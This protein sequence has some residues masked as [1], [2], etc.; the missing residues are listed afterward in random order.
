MVGV[1]GKSKGCSTCRRRKKGCDQKRPVCGQCLTSGNICGGYDRERTF[2][3]HP[4]S[5]KVQHAIFIRHTKP[6]ILPLPGSINRGA[7]ESQCKSL[8][9]DLYM[10]QGEAACRDDFIIRCG[11]PMN[12]TEVIQSVSKQDTSLADA[13]SALSISRVGQGHRDVRL[14]HESAK[15]YGKA[16]RELQLAL[17]DPQRMYSDHV[18]MA[19]MLLGLYEVFEGPAFNSRSWMAHATGAARLIQLRGPKRHQTWLTHHPFLA[20]RIPTIYAAILQRKATYLA[21]EEWRTVP[22]EFQHRTYFDRMVDLGTLIP[23]I[24]E[25]F[26]ILRECDSDIASELAQ[27][28]DECRDLQTK[29]NKWRDGTKKG[30]TPRVV[31]H[32]PL[33]QSSYPFTTDLWFENHLFV[34]ARLVYHTCSLALSEVGN[35]VLQALNLRDQKIL[36]SIDRASLKELFDAEGQAANVCRCVSYCL[37]SEMGA[38][39]ANIVNFPAN[40]AFAYYQRTGHTAATEWLEKAFRG[41]KLR[42]LHVNNVFDVLLPSFRDGDDRMRFSKRESST[43]SSSESSVHSPASNH[44]I[45]SHTFSN[46]S[47]SSDA[48]TIF[49]YEDPSK[50]YDTNYEPD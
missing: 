8:F 2:I 24:L 45:A 26:D 19:C 35:E 7:V 30:A 34:H 10:P 43:E 9:W 1:P 28:L 11:Q 18:L 6:P 36:Y 14:V 48:T 41:A 12:W 4:A 21:T 40:L 23:G 17:F 49:V 39:G 31:E 29:M 27:L 38:W 46:H 16:L 3:L 44:S 5:E 42:G 33:D 13:F 15:L 47:V 20:A 25:R 37:Q 22:W 32:D 50:D